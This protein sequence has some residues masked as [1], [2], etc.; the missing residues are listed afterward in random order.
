MRNLGDVK[1]ILNSFSPLALCVQETNLSAKHINFLRQYKVVRRDRDTAG[2]SSGGVAIIMKYNT[3]SQEIRLNTVLEAVA[4]SVVSFKTLT[5]CSIYLPPHMTVSIRDMEDLVKQ[6][7][8]PFI[9]VGD[10]NAH[11]SMWGSMTTD[12]RG[13]IIEDFLM[14]NDI[15]ILNTNA[16]TYCTPST[17]KMSS[18]DL[19]LCSPDLYVH[20]KWNVHDNPY[21]SDHLPCLVHLV[22]PTTLPTKPQRWKLHLADWTLYARHASL[23]EEYDECLSVDEINEKFTVRLLEAASMSIPQTSVLVRKNRKP[24]WTVDCRAAKKKQNKA[25]STFRRYPTYANLVNFKRARAQARYI[26]KQAEKASWRN[27]VSSISSSSPSKKVWEGVRKMNGDYTAFTIPL[28]TPPGVQTTIQDQAD[29]LGEHFAHISSSSNYNPSFLSYKAEIEK[30]NLPTKGGTKEEY[31][32]L[33]TIDELRNVL[34]MRKQTA[35]GLD[36]IHYAMIQHLSESAAYALLKFFNKVW[37]SGKIPQAWKKAVVIPLLKTG[38]P[39]TLPLSLI[40]I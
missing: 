1:D 29:L 19:A 18:I 15:C 36:N 39:H 28:L 2:R 25:R 16:P 11:S 22:Q 26:R 20:L 7:P 17:G 32:C 38:K 21:G 12:T 4:V 31:N 13:Q 24:W 9:L 30:Q 23:E 5:I 34:R 10:F 37:V 6:L 27:Y 8:T 14:T 35:P 33:F 40:H 3:T